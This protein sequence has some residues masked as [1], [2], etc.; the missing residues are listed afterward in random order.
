MEILWQ[1]VIIAAAVAAVAGIIWA[2]HRFPQDERFF[3]DRAEE[4]CGEAFSN[5]QQRIAAFDRE[6]YERRLFGSAKREAEER[7][8]ILTPEQRERYLAERE[9]S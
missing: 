5:A 3:I 2:A 9:A 6:C 8:G 1:A 4:W 7:H